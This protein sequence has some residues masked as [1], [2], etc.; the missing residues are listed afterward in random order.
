MLKNFSIVGIII[1]LLLATIGLMTSIPDD[2]IRTGFSGRDNRDAGGY[3]RYVGGDAYNFIIEASIRGGEIAGGRSARAIYLSGGMM[4]S[5]TSLIALG[6]A[7]DK[8]KKHA[9][10][11]TS[12]LPTE[13][14]VSTPPPESQQE[15]A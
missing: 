8:E 13:T 10:S 6:V 4:I 12:I 9:T 1:G 14:E 2:I 15:L 7:L 5:T 11:Q 3:Q